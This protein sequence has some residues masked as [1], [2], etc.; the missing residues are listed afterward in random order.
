[1]SQP[2]NTCWPTPDQTLLLRAALLKG[3]RA[4][5]AWEQWRE[6]VD[7]R[8]IDYGSQRLLPLLYRN[9]LDQGVRSSLMARYKGIYRH[10]WLSNHFLFYHTKPVLSAL[11][12]AGIGALLFKGAG[13]VVAGNLDYALRPMDDIDFLVREENAQTAIDIIRKLGWQ[14]KAEHAA[15]FNPTAHA[16]MYHDGKGHYIDLHW[17]SLTQALTGKHEAGYWERSLDA[18]ID[19]IPVRCMGMT[20]QLIHTCVHGI[21][22]NPIA[23]IRWIADAAVIFENKGQPVQWEHLVAHSKN[24]H[25]T[26]PMLQG[27]RYLKTEFNMPVP[28]YVLRSLENAPVSYQEKWHYQLSV[29]KNLP[30]FGGFILQVVRYWAYQRKQYPFPG[31][32]RYLQRKWGV[33]YLWQVPFEGVLRIW[34]NIRIEVFK[35]DPASIPMHSIFHE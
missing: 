20:D 23:P 24:L 3:Q 31:F 11:H 6:V 10:F 19:G 35:Q 17:Y 34:R 29:R 27:L 21:R 33:R 9:L 26:L 5:D 30:V 7:F 25:V 14:P 18:K 1:M 12:E 22:W 28:D 15:D 32:L 13:L 8:D 2:A 16:V 4:V